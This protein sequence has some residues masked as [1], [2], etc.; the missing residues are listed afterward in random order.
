MN[1]DK[2]QTVKKHINPKHWC[3]VVGDVMLDCYITGEIKRISP[4]APVPVVHK[5]GDDQRL[6]G[7]GNVALNLSGLGLKST[8]LGTIGHDDHGAK[9]TALLRHH[10]ISAQGVIKTKNPT[11]SKT[12]I[13]SGHQ[14]LLRIDNEFIDDSYT[15][16]IKNKFDTLLKKNPSIILLSDYAKGVLSTDLCQYIIKKARTKKIPVLADPKGNDIKKYQGVTI[17]TPNKKEAYELVGSNQINDDDL[18]KKLKLLCRK[19]SID[20][21]AMTQGNQGIKLIQS[22]KSAVIPASKVK[23]IYDVSGAGDTVIASIAFGLIAQFNFHDVFEF[24]NQAA[25]IVISKVGT[26]PIE[27]NEVID[28]YKSDELEQE[29]KIVTIHQ[30]E[31][32]ILSEKKKK[33]KIGFTNGCFDILHAGHVMYLEKAKNK[34]DYLILGLNSDASVKK[35]KGHSRPVI[36]EK[37]RARVLSALEAIDAIIIFN[38]TTP[39]NLIKKIKPDV[40]IKGDDYKMNQVVGAKEVLSWGGHVELVPIMQG[41]SSSSIIKKIS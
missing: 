24:A 34:V 8:I 30:L 11:T 7:A 36:G 39:L 3:L 1:I 15:K 22:K 26:S 25:G 21:I 2:L 16:L 37:D 31:K 5:T 19:Y 27:L 40:L 18:E 4:E 28:S 12:R 17:L 20:T 41:K 10:K 33:T 38:E 23:F 29:N 35:L 32:K 13:L 6:G 9:I 14:Q